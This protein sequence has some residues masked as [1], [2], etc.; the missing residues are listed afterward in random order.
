MKELNMHQQTVWNYLNKAGPKKELDV[1]I[2]HEVTQK[3]W[4]D[5][6]SISDA[7]QKRNEIEPFQ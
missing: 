3:N 1:Q 4:V 2:S 6:F 7:L 5:R